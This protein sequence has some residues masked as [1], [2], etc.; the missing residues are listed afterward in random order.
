MSLEEEAATLLVTLHKSSQHEET[1]DGP[2]GQPKENYDVSE[3]IS[4]EDLASLCA[5]LYPHSKL[6]DRCLIIRDLPKCL[7]GK[8]GA[9]EENLPIHA[10]RM[11]YCESSNG[12][13][14]VEF[15]SAPERRQILEWVRE[16]REEKRE[17]RFHFEFNVSVEPLTS[18]RFVKLLFRS[19]PY[20]PNNAEENID[21]SSLTKRC[22]LITRYAPNSED[23]TDDSNEIPDYVP[24]NDQQGEK[25]KG[26]SGSPRSSRR[27]RNPRKGNGDFHGWHPMKLIRDNYNARIVR[28]AETRSNQA[29]L[30]ELESEEAVNRIVA[31]SKSDSG[32]CNSNNEKLGSSIKILSSPRIVTLSV[33]VH[34]QPVHSAKY[35]SQCLQNIPVI[36][37]HN[38]DGD[39]DFS[40]LATDSTH[41]EK[42]MDLT[43][44]VSEEKS[45]TEEKSSDNNEEQSDPIQADRNEEQS[46]PIQ[47]DRNEERSIP[48]QVNRNEERSVPIKVH[49][50]EE[51]SENEC[52][53]QDE[54][55]PQMEI[56]KVQSTSAIELDT[57]QQDRINFL[58]NKVKELLSERGRLWTQAERDWIEL[59]RYRDEEKEQ[60][61][62]SESHLKIR[63][64]QDEVELRT[65]NEQL[66]RS[67]EY[68]RTLEAKLDDRLLGYDWLKARN[69]EDKL[70]LYRLREQQRH[71]E[72]VISKL[73]EDNRNLFKSMSDL[74]AYCQS[75]PGWDAK[76]AIVSKDKGESQVCIECE[77]VQFYR[78]SD[79]KRWEDE[80]LEKANTDGHL[81]QIKGTQG[82]SVVS[83]IGEETSFEEDEAPENI[84]TNGGNENPEPTQATPDP[85]VV[86]SES[87]LEPRNGKELETEEKQQ[88]DETLESIN[89]N[90][91]KENHE[92]LQ[93]LQEVAKVSP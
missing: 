41:T 34:F 69:N 39:A 56:R 77:T 45:Y 9:I 71:S 88:G 32:G 64:E 84:N 7:S 42:T 51:A 43:D 33:P 28:H 29:M 83:S 48:I 58:E 46:V 3:S 24:L 10:T 93:E 16:R 18:A 44:I 53:C 73:E 70:E 15:G 2:E 76:R 52:E 19:V 22:V 21:P 79:E 55:S 20:P 36:S 74:I 78:S 89:T 54:L 4:E 30:V 59:S 86:L 14:M 85:D 90:C 72:G 92:P 31:L 80:G 13:I 47:A 27:P 57:T 87:N 17:K 60:H 49:R 91:H 66:W 61:S 1:H 8:R 75:Q 6:S 40:Y 5:D 82:S 12:S 23:C 65:L 62:I 35:A 38:D 81:E 37:R 67:K 50:N 25:T 63:V 68:I 26:S 11:V